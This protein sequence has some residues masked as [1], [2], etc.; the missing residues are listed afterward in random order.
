[1]GSSG[2]ELPERRR[3]GH[4]GSRLNCRLYRLTVLFPC[5]RRAGRRTDGPFLRRALRKMSRPSF[6]SVEARSLRNLRDPA[7]GMSIR[8]SKPAA[9][10]KRIR[11]SGGSWRP[12]RGSFGT[13]FQNR[14]CGASTRCSDVVT[15]G[16]ADEG[17]PCACVRFGDVGRVGNGPNVRRS[18][19][20]LRAGRLR[21]GVS[22]YHGMYVWNE[23]LRAIA[24]GVRRIDEVDAGIER[25]A[26]RRDRFAIVHGAVDSGH[27]QATEADSG[28][29]EVAVAE[30]AR[31]L[32]TV[33]S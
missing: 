28:N 13:R 18:F 6:G 25:R 8:P 20:G 15:R 31:F 21:N 9:M 19:G 7:A 14:R 32:Q 23:P 12:G 22:P 26:Y 33:F 27:D 3:A 11:G 5:A 30:L 1:M 29:L 17:F 16:T 2:R 4:P 10:G 24:V